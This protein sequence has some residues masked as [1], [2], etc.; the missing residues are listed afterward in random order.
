MKKVLVMLFIFALFP[1][2]SIF[3]ACSFG[4]QEFTITQIE[5]ENGT[6]TLSHEKAKDGE[7]VTI[8][9]TANRGYRFGYALINNKKVTTNIFDMPNEDA[10][11]EVFFTPITYY[12]E[13][14]KD[15]TMFF[16]SPQE[17]TFTVETEIASLGYLN[18]NGY[19]F[20]GF[21]KE[22]SLQT[23]IT[24]I[25]V[26]TVG[27]VKVYPKFTLETYSV[28]YHIDSSTLNE[29]NPLTYTILDSDKTLV[30]PLKEG[31]DFKGWY[32]NES[33]LGNK[34]TKITQGSFGNINLYPKFITNKR[35]ENRFKLIETKLDFETL[36]IDEFVEDEKYKLLTDIDMGTKSW[37]PET[38]SGEFDGNNHTISNI[39]LN[40]N[41]IH[42]SFHYGMFEY[43]NGATIKNLKISYNINLTLNVPTETA[44]GVG[45][46]AGCVLN[47]SKNFI[48]NVDVVSGQ[49]QVSTSKGVNIGGL[50]GIANDNT[51]I[52]KCSVN[53]VNIT[54]T[55]SHD[56]VCVGGVSA[57]F[58]E[59]TNT[60]V[61][62]EDTNFEINN[63][64]KNSGV[65][66]DLA[67]IMALGDR[68]KIQNCY[69][70]Q[71]GK[72]KFKV[73]EASSGATVNIAG[74]LTDSLSADTT[75][76]SCYAQLREIEFI[77]KA[78]TKNCDINIAGLACDGQ[79]SNCF[80]ARSR[81]PREANDTYDFNSKQN[82][83][84]YNFYFDTYNNYKIALLCFSQKVS[85]S[86][87]EYSDVFH[88]GQ[89]LPTSEFYNEEL[90]EDITTINDILS[91][92]WDGDSWK[93]NK[94]DLNVPPVLK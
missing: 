57:K 48:E 79:V 41:S 68:S 81:K 11:V 52:N 67:G 1:L 4:A 31:Y 76:D 28:I 85:N 93:F 59:I 51:K 15:D 29:Q 49:I 62:L 69:V 60:C 22:E 34:L 70:S 18:K 44:V 63:T 64:A 7:D 47:N 9:A 53:K 21:F 42:S 74:I 24:K 20:E 88:N 39:N 73:Y 77:K 56:S 32:T 54:V 14:M 50:I 80:L 6:Y 92:S 3:T 82:E 27:N 91:K 89:V 78:V 19:K 40:S 71:K 36:F 83:K 90:F 43:L 13:Y 37:K 30:N 66:V 23:P 45:G 75:I 5:S 16:S 35:D 46:L 94:K 26:G 84:P 38:F 65:S 61:I 12:V 8:V 55:N 87:V 86:Y 10:T 17:K 25:D 33:L 72:S 2:I 58:G